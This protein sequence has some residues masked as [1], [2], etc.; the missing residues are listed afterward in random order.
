VVVVL[1]GFCLDLALLYLLQQPIQSPSA[2]LVLAV[3][4]V[5]TI[6]EP[7][8]QIQYSLRLPPLAGDMERPERVDLITEALEV[9]AAALLGQGLAG[10]QPPVKVMQEEM[11]LVEAETMGLAAAAVLARSGL[12]EPQ[13]PAVT[14]AQALHHQLPGH[15]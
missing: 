8:D 11:V 1:V 5:E 2:V 10:L 3:Q 6:M 13:Q 14:E 15:Q 9:L 7:L 4:P 12:R